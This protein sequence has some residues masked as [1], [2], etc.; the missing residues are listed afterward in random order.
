L[1]YAK[2]RLDDRSLATA[3]DRL[4][5]IDDPLARSLVWGAAWDATRDAETSPSEYITLVLNNIGSETESTTLRTTL[6]QLTT[7]ARLYMDPARRAQA[8]ETV[9]DGL[10]LLAQD[11]APASDAQFQ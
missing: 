4:E 3:M 1:A 2:I 7:T 5:D 8:I 6:T 9:G 10:W 11:A